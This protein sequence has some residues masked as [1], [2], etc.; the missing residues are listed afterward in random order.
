MSFVPRKSL[1]QNFLL[2]Q[3]IIK[4][5]VDL[6][7][8][9]NESTVIEIGPGTGN[10]TEEIIKKK[11]K[12]FFAIEKDINL[13]SKLNN[14]YKSDLILMNQDVLT[15]NWQSLVKNKCIDQL[16]IKKSQLCH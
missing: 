14:K 8:L 16:E 3:K 13:F 11:P 12:D 5:I 4:K 6:G 10:L 2:N 1:G 9:N 15:I 7:K